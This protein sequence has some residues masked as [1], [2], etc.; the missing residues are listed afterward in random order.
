MKGT[1]RIGLGV[2][3]ALMVAAIVTIVV[4]AT[5]ARS[6][7]LEYVGEGKEHTDKYLP[8]INSNEKAPDYGIIITG[9][10]VQRLIG[11]R[12]NSYLK[13]GQMV[14]SLPEPVPAR[15]IGEVIVFD[16]DLV[17][18]DVLERMTFQP[19]TM[20]GKNYQVKAATEFS[21]MGGLQF[22]WMTAVG[23]AI[24]AGISIGFIVLI[25]SLLGGAS[26]GL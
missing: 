24:L 25:L 1:T 10:G 20:T 5:S 23:K 11:V 8:G 18:N 14:F 13:D 2:V 16:N 21:L 7:I 9:D 6:F 12:N 19:G 26:L 15:A 3:A 17:E 22:F 4:G